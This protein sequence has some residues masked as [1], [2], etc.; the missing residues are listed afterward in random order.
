MTTVR[1]FAAALQALPEDQQDLPFM[2]CLGHSPE[3]YIE[4]ASGK[5]YAQ[6]ETRRE[7]G[8]DPEHPN[9]I[10]TVETGKIEHIR[11]AQY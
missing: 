1:E 8:T 3:C 2:T 4:E 9:R 7:A 6:P 5:F 11:P 10:R